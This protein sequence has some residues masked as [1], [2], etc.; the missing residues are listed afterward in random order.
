MKEL[1]K[2]LGVE[3]HYHLIMYLDSIGYKAD[4]K[5]IPKLNHEIETFLYSVQQ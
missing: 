1:M 5:D 4:I 3:N 2:E